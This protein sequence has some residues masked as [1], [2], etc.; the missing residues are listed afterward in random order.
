[1]APEKGNGRIVSPAHDVPGDLSRVPVP[2][3]RFRLSDTQIL[4]E[5]RLKSSACF[6]SMREANYLFSPPRSRGGCTS[7]VL[8]PVQL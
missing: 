3:S 8:P 5:Y 7:R 2:C 6:I 1:M 4:L